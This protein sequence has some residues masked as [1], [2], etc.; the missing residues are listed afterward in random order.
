MT[1]DRDIINGNSDTS[2]GVDVDISRRDFIGGVAVAPLILSSC[3]ETPRPNPVDPWT[4]Y[5]GIGDYAAANGNTAGVVQAAHRIRDFQYPESV[6][7]LPYVDD[8][9]DLVVVGGGFS[10]IAAAYDFMHNGEGRCLVLENHPV[11]GGEAKQ[12]EFNVDGV[13]LTAPQGSN[14][15]R[16][17]DPSDGLPYEL[18]KELGLPTQFGYRSPDGAPRDV[19]FAHDNYEPMFWSDEK[20]SVGY[21][22]QNGG[23]TNPTMVKDIWTDRLQRA[24]WPE[25]TK[26]D[27]LNWRFGKASS[28]AIEAEARELDSMS[29]EQ[30]LTDRLGLKADVARYADPILAAGS[31][32]L[33]SDAV[34]AYAARLLGMPGVSPVADKGSSDSQTVHSFPGGNTAILRRMVKA[35][36]PN[37]IAGG[38]SPEDIVWNEIQ[39]GELDK[40]TNKVRIR[41]GSTVFHVS[42]EGDPES[43]EHV[44]ISYAKSGKLSRL[45]AKAVVMANGAWVNRHILADAGER[46]KKALAEFRHAPMLVVNVALNNW[47]FLAK[48]GVSAAHWFDNSLGF[49]CNIRAPMLVDGSAP[50]FNPNKPT[51]LTL[52]IAFPSPGQPPEI[53]GALARTKMFNTSFVDY[54]R[55][56]RAKLQHMFGQFGFDSKRDIAAIILNR[57]GHAYVSPQPGFFF[58]ANGEGGAGDILREG[59]GRIYFGHSELTGR[60]NWHAAVRE[61][62]RAARQARGVA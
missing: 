57:W 52:Y 40:P 41:L 7:N 21:F 22:F 1:A 32:G 39:F 2:L 5:A 14:D 59:Y 51:V 8:V 11:F 62:N 28:A 46:Q 47:R 27:L 45:R 25:D 44:I 58:G 36:L 38:T 26:R 33:G 30:F 42:H 37:S 56:V 13:H 19:K 23:A 50:E 31:Y 4:G 49:F 20:Y 24:P 29:Y 17:L 60:Q 35:I 18:W 48:A 9:Y 55:A 53:Q 10:G 6:S 16:T 61:G 3:A 12:N 15:F 43:A 54:E 34:S